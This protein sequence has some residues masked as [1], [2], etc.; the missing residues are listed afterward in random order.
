MATIGLG[1]VTASLAASDPPATPAE[2]LSGVLQAQSLFKQQRYAE[3][4]PLLARMTREDPANG[5]LWLY[6]AQS[7]DQAGNAREAVRAYEEVR[8]LDFDTWEDD[9]TAAGLYA[10]KLHQ[11][12]DALRW[13]K[14]AIYTSRLPGRAQ[15]LTD[16]TFASLRNDAT[17]KQLAGVPLRPEKS[18]VGKW[19]ADIDFFVSEAQRLHPSPTR[20]AFSRPFLSAA[21]DLKSKVAR[22]SDDEILLEVMKLGVLLHDAHTQVIG[23]G[24]W[25][26]WTTMRFTQIDL[27][28][29]SDGYFIMNG[30]GAARDHVGAQVLAIG[31]VPFD[32]LFKEV[33][34]YVSYDNFQTRN[35][36]SRITLEWPLVLWKLGALKNPDAS[37]ARFTIKD[38]DGT[39]KDIDV[40]IAPGRRSSKLIPSL[41]SN[42]P[43]PLYLQRP[44]DFLWAT[45]RPELDG[46]W[47]QYNQVLDDPAKSLAQMADELESML[48][49][50]HAKNLII[51]VRRNNGGSIQGDPSRLLEVV[52]AFHRASPSNRIFV[53]VGRNTYS[54]TPLWIGELEQ[55]VPDTIFVGEPASSG[56][57]FTG[58]EGAANLMPYSKLGFNISNV[59]HSTAPGLGQRD[60]RPYIPM[61]MPVELT[62]KEYFNNDDPAYDAVKDFLDN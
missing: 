24:G 12:G 55:L 16:D 52:A 35:W 41:I 17:F 30:A 56:S 4:A 50:A 57:N 8:R 37:S 14:R 19:R 51:D 54:A 15:L 25:D 11:K 18:R 29:F 39:V 49:D 40:P 1:A 59:W 58:E 48:A 36:K 9:Y 2:H 28:G 6:Q 32:R 7:Y 31:G 5:K 43:A 13:L 21:A 20:E 3:A 26:A 53:I 33:A 44:G 42:R 23:I 60:R 45:P 62:S 47:F 10:S 22:L 27:W 46:V 34:P 38:R 61:D